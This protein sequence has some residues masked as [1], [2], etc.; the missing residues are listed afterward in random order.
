MKSLLVILSFISVVILNQED[1]RFTRARNRMVTTQIEARGIS[2]PG[3]LRAMRTVPRHLFV[4]P[5]YSSE[6]YSDRPLP[7]GYN[8]TIS[9][10]FIVA[11][12]TQLVRPARGK[13]AL[14]IGTGSGYQAAVLAEIVD[15]VYTIEIVGELARE[16]AARLK[17][18][19]YRNIV[20]KYG[21][22]YLGWPEHAP[23]DII[24]VTAAAD[25]IPQ[26]LREQM[27]EGG[28]LVMPVGNPAYVQELVVL[29]KR[30]GRITEQ[31]LEPVRFV[32]LRRLKE[33]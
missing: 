20:T 4:P 9:Q 31:R 14:E 26:P 23:F 28:R 5:S 13:I 1:S 30:K 25:H 15:T 24:I 6:A 22:G 33:N 10:P 8:Q 29:S 2:D 3:T 17:V 18:L 11:Y 7:I 12:M 21:D 27:A 32:P 19:G 16:S